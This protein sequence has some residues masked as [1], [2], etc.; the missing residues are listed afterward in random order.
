[1]LK[2]KLRDKSSVKLRELLREMDKA[3]SDHD[4][5]GWVGQ[6][7]N[8]FS[9]TLSATTGCL[10]FEPADRPVTDQALLNL[11]EAEM[12]F[13]KPWNTWAVR[14]GNQCAY[15]PITGRH[16]VEITWARKAQEGAEARV[17]NGTTLVA[18]RVIADDGREAPTVTEFAAAITKAQEGIQE[19]AMGLMK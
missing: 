14:L 15:I 5:P 1:M 19:L 6:M 13:G 18:V 9:N 3:S 16:H 8:A 2:P 10:A 7:L 4:H 12:G 11:R 17:H